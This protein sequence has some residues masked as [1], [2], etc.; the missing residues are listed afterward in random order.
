MVSSN[1]N[2]LHSSIQQ[3]LL[4]YNCLFLLELLNTQSCFSYVRAVA[5]PLNTVIGGGLVLFISQ[6]LRT[7]ELISAY[8]FWVHLATKQKRDFIQEKIT[9]HG[10]SMTY[11]AKFAS[12]VRTPYFCRLIKSFL[13]QI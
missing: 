5:I 8:D 11:D 7:L 3:H 1:G 6:A 10:T 13:I 9:G 4:G 12:E 2:L